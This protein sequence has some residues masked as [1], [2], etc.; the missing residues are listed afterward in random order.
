VLAHLPER[1]RPL[2]RKRLRQACALDDHAVP[3]ERLQ[4]LV[5]SGSRLRWRGAAHPR[6]RTVR[7]PTFAGS[8]PRIVYSVV[9]ARRETVDHRSV[10]AD[11]SFTRRELRI[12]VSYARGD[13]SKVDALE[14]RLRFLADDVWVDNRLVG[15]HDWWK[16]IL[17]QIRSCDV[18][19][20]AV[21]PA[22]IES[23]ACTRER[24]YAHALK[25]PVLPVEVEATDTALLPD[26]LSTL[27]LVRYTEP[28]EF[29]ALGLAA[30]VQ[31]LPPTP[32]LPDPL[33]GPPEVPVPEL[34]AL[35]T[36]LHAE[37]LPV[38]EQP[39]IIARLEAALKRDPERQAAV[40]LLRQLDRRTDLAAGPAG[41]IAELIDAER[42]HD[43]RVR[44]R[45]RAQRPVHVS[46][47]PPIA[48]LA[49]LIAALLAFVGGW[50]RAGWTPPKTTPG[51]DR[52]LALAYVRTPTW[53][54]IVAAVAALIALDAGSKPAMDA[55]WRGL[56]AGALAGLASSIVQGGIA[57]VNS[58]DTEDKAR[59]FSLAVAGVITGAYFGWRVHARAA[60]LAVGLAAVGLATGVLAGE[61]L[62]DWPRNNAPRYVN[63]VS[64]S[65]HVAPVYAVVVALAARRSRSAD[66]TGAPH[67]W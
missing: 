17:S 7:V 63:A 33:P 31:A 64:W 44:R 21:S 32:P 39:R 67:V 42:R 47:R 65:V 59:L 23:L 46:V 10:S 49:L 66:R 8:L 61:L 26:D 40:E 30:A 5:G 43:G 48:G 19:V 22:A 2:V 45:S 54:L 27:Q 56:A 60:A 28:G 35:R 55:A 15:G 18:F 11:R 50:V 24:G 12:F 6:L 3:L 38:E 14:A 51:M 4:A 58:W 36:L 29:Q 37:S 25:K 34:R 52:L 20:Q 16:E 53:A 1:D 41:R 9:A 62:L 13:R 57:Y